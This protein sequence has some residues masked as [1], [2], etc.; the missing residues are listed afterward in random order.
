MWWKGLEVDNTKLVGFGGSWVY[1]LASRVV[2]GTIGWGKVT[3][4]ASY[5]C[6]I[7]GEVRGWMWVLWLLD[8]L[9]CD[10]GETPLQK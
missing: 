1:W 9:G 8:V 2:R 5:G 3:L 6:L 10:P 7:L 4:G